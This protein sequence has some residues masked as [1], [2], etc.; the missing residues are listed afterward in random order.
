MKKNRSSKRFAKVSLVLSAAL[1]IVAATAAPAFAED[2]LVIVEMIFSAEQL[3]PQ[4]GDGGGFEAVEQPVI[5]DAGDWEMVP[6][7]T[8]P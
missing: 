2:Q 1:L 7:T 5:G 3:Q 8:S 4:I 6:S